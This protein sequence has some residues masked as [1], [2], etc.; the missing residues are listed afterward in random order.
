[1]TQTSPEG[2]PYCPFPREVIQLGLNVEAWG[3]GGGVAT[4][5][6]ATR[7]TKRESLTLKFFS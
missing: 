4:L 2:H 6:D 1:M 5:L 7:G 3:G